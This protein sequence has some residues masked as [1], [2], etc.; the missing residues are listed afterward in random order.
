MVDAADYVV[1]QKGFGVR[2]DS[3]DYADWRTSFGTSY[4]AGPVLGAVAVPE[5]GMASMVLVGCA[6]CVLMFRRDRS[7]QSSWQREI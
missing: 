7:R 4:G 5:P 3:Q 2:Y 6:S 1:F